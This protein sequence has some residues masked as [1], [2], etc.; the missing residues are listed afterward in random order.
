MTLSTLSKKDFWDFHCSTKRSVSRSKWST[1]DNCLLAANAKRRLQKSESTF[2]CRCFSEAFHKTTSHRRSCR[3]SLKTDRSAEVGHFGKDKSSQGPNSENFFLSSVHYWIETTRL[4]DRA[5]NC[6]PT[7]C[8][9]KALALKWRHQRSAQ[10]LPC[11]TQGLRPPRWSRWRCYCGSCSLHGEPICTLAVS[12]LATRGEESSTLRKSRP[13]HWRLRDVQTSR[14]R[15]SSLRG[16]RENRNLSRWWLLIVSTVFSAFARSRISGGG[17]WSR[18]DCLRFQNKS[19]RGLS[20]LECREQSPGRSRIDC[21]VW[22]ESI[23]KKIYTL[24]QQWFIRKQ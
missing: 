7:T 6:P 3:A 18:A 20:F 10:S 11:P 8:R 1:G 17:T 15:R 22:N 2:L 5:P 23:L 19:F 4:L 9:R 24:N 13:R 14:F 12:D 21:S 16:V